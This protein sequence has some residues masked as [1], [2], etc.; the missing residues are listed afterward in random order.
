MAWDYWVSTGVTAERLG[1]RLVRVGVPKFTGKPGNVL[2]FG[3][4][5][6]SCPG[7]VISDSADVKLEGVD[8]F[9]CGG[10]GVIAQRSRDIEL[11]RV[12]VHDDLIVSN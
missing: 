7:I 6:R 3:A 9:H 2:V 5:S 1:P 11:R 12:W 10:M 8:I 4:A